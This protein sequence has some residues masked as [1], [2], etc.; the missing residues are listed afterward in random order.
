[1][2][3]LCRVVVE[4]DELMCMKILISSR[5][6][7]HGSND[8]SLFSFSSSFLPSLLHFLTFCQE[9]SWSNIASPQ[10]LEME[11]FKLPSYLLLGLSCNLLSKTVSPLLLKG[12]RS[13]QALCW[14]P[15]IKPL[16]NNPTDT[17]RGRVKY[18]MRL[19]LLWNLKK[20]KKWVWQ[21]ENKRR[22]VI[23]SGKRKLKKKL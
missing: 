16:G 4:L 15:W 9:R 21:S 10:E 20:G 6:S 13:N 17:G 14:S 2:I 22:K 7:I 3:I 5:P 18:M 12:A 19:S 1:M 11:K 8:S 23:K